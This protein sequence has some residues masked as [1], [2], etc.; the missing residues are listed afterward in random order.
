MQ[1]C[2][3]YWCA[4]CVYQVGDALVGF[5]CGRGWFRSWGLLWVR[6]SRKGF[7]CGVEDLLRERRVVASAGFEEELAGGCALDL[8]ICSVSFGVSLCRREIDW[9]RASPA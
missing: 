9:Y 3:A 4:G 6:G 5:G 8:L 1:G 2:E 7:S